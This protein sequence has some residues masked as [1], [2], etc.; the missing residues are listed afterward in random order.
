MSTE[1]QT[2]T[3]AVPDDQKA[4]LIYNGACPV[5]DA[6]V[7]AFRA[8]DGQTGY[9][10]I[11][12]A[13]QILT[14]HGLTAQDV[15]FRVHALAPDGRLVRGI[16]AVAVMLSLKRGWGWAGALLGWPVFRQ[17]GWLAYETAAIVLFRWN[18]WRGNF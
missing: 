12:T 8:D 15:Q 6:G 13:P 2:E 14:R 7:Q 3:P 10:D 17:L 1:T 11:T 16:D 5:C 9:V 18:K 4:Q